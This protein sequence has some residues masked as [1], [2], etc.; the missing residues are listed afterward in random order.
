MSVTYDQ[1]SSTVYI[2]GEGTF[3][4]PYFYFADTYTYDQ[5]GGWNVMLRAN[6]FQYYQKCRVIITNSYVVDDTKQALIDPMIGGSGFIIRVESGFL[7]FGYTNNENIYNCVGGVG[8][9]FQQ[10]AQT[11]LMW[12][13]QTN[14][15][16]HLYGCSIRNKGS[17]VG[18]IACTKG[19]LWNN[20]LDGCYFL[21]GNEVSDYNNT[22]ENIYRGYS[23]F[24]PES[25]GLR[26]KI[27]NV[28]YWPI[29]PDEWMNGKHVTDLYCREYESLVNIQDHFSG[30]DE[31]TIYVG[32]G[33]DVDNW[34]VNFRYWVTG[35]PKVVREHRFNFKVVDSR[36]VPIPNATVTLFNI[37]WDQIFS[38]MTDSNGNIVQQVVERSYCQKTWP[39]DTGSYTEDFKL[40][41]D[42]NPTKDY[43]PFIAKVTKDGY[44]TE[45]LH[46]ITLSSDFQGQVELSRVEVVSTSR[47]M[48]GEV[49]TGGMMK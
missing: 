36:G 46:G 25:I 44:D 16:L 40:N 9:I 23:S 26:D 22:L 15:E 3:G 41:L 39:D 12:N 47:D 20:R 19:R 27:F 34:E 42:T 5:A 24:V 11:Y 38:V 13:D 33:F 18:I 35:N 7:R 49:P 8:F 43:G 17:Q 10:A 45:Y 21:G 4:S 28:G 30:T 29:T 14:G 37:D 31:K 48:L 2:D 6:L 32:Q 1:P